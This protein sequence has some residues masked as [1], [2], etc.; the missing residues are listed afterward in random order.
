MF[1]D[2]KQCFNDGVDSMRS[3]FADFGNGAF[4][5]F[6]VLVLFFRKLSVWT[7]CES[8]SWL[9]STLKNYRYNSWASSLA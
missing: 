3:A 5:A 9:A 1:D 7:M 2:L 8:P 4:P 6:L